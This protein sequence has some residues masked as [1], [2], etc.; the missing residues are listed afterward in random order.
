MDEIR[1][2]LEHVL[3]NLKPYATLLSGFAILAGGAA[4]AWAKTLIHLLTKDDKQKEPVARIRTADTVSKY[5]SR[6]PS[7]VARNQ[8]AMRLYEAKEAME[9]QKASAKAAKISSN[10]LT[11]GQY[12]IG[13]VLAS[14]FVQEALSAKWVGV[15]GVL[16][17]IASLVKQQFHPEINAAE[18]LKK[19]AQLKALIRLSED[20]FTILDAKIASGQDQTDAMI[21]LL[22]QITQKLNEIENDEPVQI[23][24]RSGTT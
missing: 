17:L 8:T 6:S 4:S 2:F 21:A 3:D 10:L 13:G 19:A 9:E 15:L 23:T 20:Q 14:S 16:V 5:E 18:A 22:A 7:Q 12:I 1:K 24:S 11:I